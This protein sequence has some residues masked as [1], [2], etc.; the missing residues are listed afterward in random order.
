MSMKRLAN[1]VELK[2][3]MS[4]AE[5]ATF[6]HMVRDWWDVIQAN[7]DTTYH[8]GKMNFIDADTE[9]IFR[10]PNGK[11]WILS[12]DDNGDVITTEKTR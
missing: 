11:M 5:L 3:N 4:A 8:R 1:P 7:Y 10:S 12:V 2:A 9:I 6:N